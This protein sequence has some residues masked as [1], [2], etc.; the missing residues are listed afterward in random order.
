MAQSTEPKFPRWPN[1]GT[2]IW[3]HRKTQIQILRYGPQR[4]T[5]FATVTQSVGNFDFENTVPFR[6]VAISM[7]Q[8]KR[9]FL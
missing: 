3:H 1:A 9:Y 7:N 8:T 2:Q 4:S 5:K 6:L